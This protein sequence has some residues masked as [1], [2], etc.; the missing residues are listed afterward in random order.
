[1]FPVL[2]L[3]P[4]VV[5]EAVRGVRDHLF[6]Y[7]DAQIWALA[8]LNQIGAVLSEDFSAGAVIEGVRFIDPFSRTFDV[9]ELA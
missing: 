3:T 2:P 6:S 7:Y 5:L 8:R 1:M 4:A 9:E